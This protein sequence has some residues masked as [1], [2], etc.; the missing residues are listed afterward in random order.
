MVAMP[1]TDQFIFQYSQQK[2]HWKGLAHLLA[3]VMLSHIPKIDVSSLGIGRKGFWVDLFDVEEINQEQLQVFERA[4][5]ALARHPSIE[6]IEIQ[7][8]SLRGLLRSQGRYLRMGQLPKEDRILIP[9]FRYLDHIEP[10]DGEAICENRFPCMAL[11]GTESILRKEGG[12]SFKGVRIF[13][14]AFANEKA[15]RS[16]RATWTVPQEGWDAIYRK[17]HEGN[18]WL[19]SRWCD[20]E[21][22]LR[23][24]W[25]E[26]IREQG[27]E[28]TLRPGFSFSDPPEG[29]A[30]WG[31]LAIPKEKD[32]MLEK[33]ALGRAVFEGSSQWAQNLIV[34]LLDHALIK[35]YR[36]DISPNAIVFLGKEEHGLELELASIIHRENGII[37]A[38][39][40]DSFYR[41]A[42][43]SLQNQKKLS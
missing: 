25:E 13:G 11:L 15:L 31:L 38:T 35:N 19:K 29:F 18:L 5:R 39:F 9:C 43:L 28:I 10:I 32:P 34:K 33:A 14:A 20:L 3:F 24:I 4:L 42:L 1:K 8:S 41:W 22:A 16:F 26:K 12:K 30:E 7:T 2:P 23:S 21:S 17:D 27:I 40:V 6:S 37:I 36:I